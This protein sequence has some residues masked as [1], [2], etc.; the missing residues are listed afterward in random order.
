MIKCGNSTGKG[1]TPYNRRIQIVPQGNMAK[2][3]N[4]VKNCKKFT[5]YL[6]IMTHTLIVRFSFVSSILKYTWGI[7][8]N[9]S[10]SSQKGPFITWIDCSWMPFKVVKVQ[11]TRIISII[12][13][14]TWCICDY[15]TK[16]AKQNAVLK[17]VKDNMYFDLSS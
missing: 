13:L 16:K 7:I 15:E 4:N 11:I 2:S 17:Q 6:Q 14:G 9:L 1:Q 5:Y 10:E 8:Q 3:M 12:Q